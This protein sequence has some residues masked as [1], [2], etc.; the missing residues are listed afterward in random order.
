MKLFGFEITRK[1]SKEQE[2]LISIVPPISTDG[3]TIVTES[4]ALGGYYSMIMDLE[5]S[6]KN[7]NDLIRRYR[8]AAMYP[9]CDSAIDEIINEAI[10]SDGEESIVELNLD[11]IDKSQL[12]DSIKKKLTEEFNNVLDLLDFPRCGT[13]IFRTWYVDGRLFYHMMFVEGKE[14][15]GIKELRYIDPRKIKK[16]K[17][18]KKERINGV[19]VIKEVREYYVYNDGGITSNTA[20]GIPLSADSVVYAP[21]GIVDNTGT[22]AISY[23]HKAVKH[24]NMLKM[25]E[26]ALVIYRITR[27]PERRIFYIDVGNL[28]KQKAEQYV[29][30]IMNRYKNKISYDA[31]T[32]E[33]RDDRKFMSMMEDFWMPRREGGKGTEITTLPGGQ[34]LGQIE[35]VQFFQQKLYQA[36]NVPLGRLQPQTGFSLGRTTEITREEVKFNKYI[37]KLR[38]KFNKLFLDILKIQVVSKGIMKIEDWESIECRINFVYSKDNHFSELKDNEVMNTRLATLQQVDPMVGKYFSKEWVMKKVLRLSDDEIE[39]MQE[40]I[41]NE[42]PVEQEQVP[43]DDQQQDIGGEENE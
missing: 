4:G 13:D 7:E 30:D 3:S 6:V 39:E 21:S 9:D 43:Q 17:D 32:G 37:T 38:S 22:T 19:D 10:V 26:D 27:A 36:L 16:V 33:V 31:N 8:D 24:V 40:Q 28:P 35:D 14:K 34:T 11:K 15:E 2:K 18:V 25:M 29:T 42:M 41:E 1:S 20:T 5:G 12:P 23:L